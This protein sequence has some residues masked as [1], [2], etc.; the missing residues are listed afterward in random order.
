MK[1]LRIISE[2]SILKLTF[3]RNTEFISIGITQL[4]VN[5][6]ES[7]KNNGAMGQFFRITPEFSILKLTSLRNTEFIS[8]GITQPIVNMSENSKNDDALG[9]SFQDYTRVQYFEAD[10]LKKY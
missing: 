6:S 5:M 1:V 7:S 9:E 8:I 3:L 2:F 4:I 10:F